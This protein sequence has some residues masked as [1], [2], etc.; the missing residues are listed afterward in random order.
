MSTTADQPEPKHLSQDKQSETSITRFVD[1][2][3][4]Q[5]PGKLRAYSKTLWAVWSDGVYLTAWPRMAA[6]LVFAVFAFGF[7]EGGTHWSMLSL[8]GYGLASGFHSA[9]FAQMLPLMTLAVLLGSFSAN[10]GLMLVIGFALGDFFWSGVPF[11]PWERNLALPPTLY[12]RVPQLAAY[13][14]FFFLAAWPITANKFLVAAAHRRFRE[15]E[16]W[17][18]VFMVIVQ[19]LFIY[20]WTYFAPMGV[21]Q[22]WDCCMQTSPLDVRYFHQTTLPWLLAAAFVGVVARRVL[23]NV[24]EK[25]DPNVISRLDAACDPAWAYISRMPGWL[26][27]IIGA[28]IMTLLFLGF[29]VSLPRVIMTFAAVLVLM[30]LRTS[31]LAGT[32]LWRG[33]TTRLARYPAV[34]RLGLATVATYLAS[35]L[36]LTVPGWGAIERSTRGNF[37]PELVSVLIGLLIV[38]VLLPNGTFV[39][40]EAELADNSRPSRVPIPSPVIQAGILISLVL[41]ASKRALATD[42]EAGRCCYG[43][44][45]GLAGSSTAAGTPSGAAVAGPGGGFSFTG[46]LPPG[47]PG[48]STNQTGWR[49]ATGPV[50]VRSSPSNDSPSV[51]SIPAGTAGSTF[52]YHGTHIDSNG[53]TWFHVVDSEDPHYGWGIGN[54]WIT[55]DVGWATGE[56]SVPGMGN[57]GQPSLRTGTVQTAAARG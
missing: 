34:I 10:L 32:S 43:G 15:S 31:V 9:S 49:T 8:N 46:G 36:V 21:K 56:N 5:I 2:W 54:Q 17:K 13:L 52:E 27:A 19:G 1:F 6:I 38:L 42:C 40:E 57:D 35:R 29:A 55:S 48:S 37:A 51:D 39:S 44:D 12:G 18:T 7:F 26:H 41:L 33:W 3:W 47:I 4:I 22:Q 50:T 16:V 53:Q 20:E 14:V 11:S 25:S 45:N 24:A 23:I 30:L 28:V